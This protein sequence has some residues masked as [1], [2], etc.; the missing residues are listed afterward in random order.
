HDREAV[1]RGPRRDDRSGMTRR[2][3]V[4][5]GGLAGITTALDLAD[6]GDDVVMLERRRHLGG[7]TWSFRR[8]G[9]WFDNGQHAFLPPC[10][11]RR[12]RAHAGRP[13]GRPPTP[14]STCPSSPLTAPGRRCA[15]CRCRRPSTS[16][17]PWP[18][19][20]TSGWRTAPGPHGARSRCAVSTMRIPPSTR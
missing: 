19:T 11:A 14:A 1:G 3:V 20:A 18:G 2:V 4:V 13:P 5:G 8:G 7:L 12:P 10:P 6:A 15:G 9:L 17:P 16:V